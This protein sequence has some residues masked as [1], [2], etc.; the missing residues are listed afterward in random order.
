MKDATLF[1]SSV[2]SFTFDRKGVPGLKQADRISNGRITNHLQNYGYAPCPSTP[3]LWRHN[4]LPIIF[5]IVFDNFSVKYTGK[6]NADH[7][8]NALCALYTI[9]VKQT[10]SL[11]CWL[12]LTCDYARG[13]VNISMPDYIKQ[14]LHKFKHPMAPKPEDAHHKCKQ[15]VYGA[16][17]QLSNVEDDIPVLPPLD[18]THIK[19]VVG[20]ILHHAIAVDNTMLV[21]LGNLDSLQTKGTQKTLEALTQLLNYSATHQN[22]TVRFWRSGMILHIHSDGS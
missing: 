4:T 6:H 7:L 21:T 16:K 12:N 1:R 20:K 17:Q 3:A 19:T 8:M 11:Y 22:S 18:I 2:A 5:T 10:G 15:P 13:H 9:T 14:A